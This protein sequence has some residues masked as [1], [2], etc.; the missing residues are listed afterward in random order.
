MFGWVLVFLS[1]L[2]KNDAELRVRVCLSFFSQPSKRMRNFVLWC[3]LVFLTR[4][5]NMKKNFVVGC[6]LAFSPDL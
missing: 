4:P 1:K 5:L 6:V 3:V 2:L